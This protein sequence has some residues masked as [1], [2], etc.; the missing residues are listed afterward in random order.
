METKTAHIN[1]I[2]GGFLVCAALFG[3]AT[4]AFSSSSPGAQAARTGRV[5]ERARTYTQQ[6]LVNPTET[7]R[8]RILYRSHTGAVRPAFVLVPRSYRQ[9][10]HAP[11][12]LVISPHGRG[13]PAEDNVHRWGNL[14]GIGGFAVVSPAG[15]GDRLGLY[16]WGARGQI[17][18]LARMP[19]IVSRRIPWLKIDRSQIYAFG[20]SMG[21]QETLLLVARHPRLLAGAVAIDSLV[22]FPL[23]YRNFPRV[24]CGAGCRRAW[25]GPIGL[26]L[27]KFA[28]IEVGGTP[29]TAPAEY[30]ARSSL[31]YAKRIARSCVPL[32]IWWSRNDR[33]V[34]DSWKQ[35]GHLFRAI[36]RAN[37]AA[38]VAGYVGYWHH[39]AAL[40]AARYL[41]YA[42][43]RFGLMPSV[44]DHLPARPTLI[45]PPAQACSL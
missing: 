11:I 24:A 30:A 23:Q 26:S 15:Q 41:P 3:S 18:D 16:S 19:A 44:F 31:T 25:G 2:C 40:R 27:Q 4:A 12:P 8:I 28:Q 36:R 45:S 6:Q 33:T 39:A 43:A 13:V 21:G 9:G 34:V 32:Q 5:A 10:D 20:G 14:P 17:E 37:D 29:E 38:P 35:S 22:D 1:R 42:L 7:R